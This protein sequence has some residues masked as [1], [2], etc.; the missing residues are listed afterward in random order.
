L[1][2][3]IPE[4][5]GQLSNLK[6]LD[7]GFNYLSGTIPDRFFEGATKLQQLRVNNNRLTGLFPSHIGHIS[8][9]LFMLHMEHNL[10][11]GSIPEEVFDCKLLEGLWLHDNALTGTI[12]SRVGELLHI[13]KCKLI[14]CSRCM[15]TTLFRAR[16]IQ[17][18]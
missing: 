15:L 9:T 6:N 18:F 2:G 8:S 7:L 3:T 17:F 10:F 16:N 11:S 12:P 4:E 13:D 1:R 14:S 5:Y